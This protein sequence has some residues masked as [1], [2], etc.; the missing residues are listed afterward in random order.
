MGGG[1]RSSS[2]RSSESNADAP[3]RSTAT[4]FWL[5]VHGFCCLISLVLGFRFSRLVLFLVISTSSSPSATTIYTALRTSFPSSSAAPAPSSRVAVGR[6]GILIR[7][8]P[9]PDPSEV[10]KAHGII[11]RVQLE[12]RNQFGEKNPRTV[13][14]ITPTYVRTFQALHLTGVMHS[15]MNLPY[16]VVWI[17]V[18]ASVAGATT[19]E[20]ADLISKSGLKTIHIGFKGRI[21][22]LWD[23]RRAL[24]SKM[25]IHALRVVRDKRLEGIVVFA[26]DSNIHSMEF[27]DEIQ[28]VRR[29]GAVSIGILARSEK[30]TAQGPVCNSSGHLIGWHAF[31]T[32]PRYTGD[33]PKKLE[34]AGFVLNSRLLW[35]G[36]DKPVRIK[37]FEE[38]VDSPLSMLS[39]MSAVEPLGGC[40]RK[41][42]L[43]WA[44]VEARADSKFPAGWRIDPPLSITV[45]AKRTPWPETPPEL[46]EDSRKG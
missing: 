12:Q 46:P 10:M 7:P 14:A 4:V 31:D 40:G 19:N 43:W 41:V 21:P 13:I 18:E 45:R 38:V 33:M 23:D 27:F 8:W 28:K 15:L 1:R 11:S 22:L 16:D 30:M 35:D 42:L 17:V 36:S 3:N 6:H 5:L 44:R 26:D 29:I 24:D 2:L 39:D 34:W 9:H 25:R 37:D 32:S 20:T